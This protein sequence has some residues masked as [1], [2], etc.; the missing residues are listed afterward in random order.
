MKL[1]HQ[2]ETPRTRAQDVDAAAT[3][4]PVGRGWWLGKVKN[5]IIIIKYYYHTLRK[6]NH[7]LHHKVNYC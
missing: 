7:D 4:R 1:Y 2:N 5:I 3:P 6:K